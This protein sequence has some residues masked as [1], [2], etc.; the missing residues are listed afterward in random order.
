[1]STDRLTHIV[2]NFAI[3]KHK[4]VLK[5]MYSPNLGFKSNL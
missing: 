5:G 4:R 1:M 3:Y 2:D